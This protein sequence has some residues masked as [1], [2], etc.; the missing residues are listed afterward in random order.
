LV[1]GITDTATDDYYIV[2]GESITVN[3]EQ[4]LAEVDDEPVENP[5]EGTEPS[6]PTDSTEPS[7]PTNGTEPD[8]TEPTESPRGEIQVVV[9]GKDTLYSL[10]K[11]YGV[12]IEDLMAYNG[13]SDRNIIVTGSTLKIP[14]E[15][16]SPNEGTEGT[17]PSDPTEGP[18]GEIRIVVSS[19]DTLYSIAKTYGV[20]IEDLMAY[21]GISDRNIIV[22]GSTLKIPPEGWHLEES[23]EPTE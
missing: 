9:S 2:D 22:T 20:S 3:I 17:E 21:N 13:I 19:K 7:E 11:T 16:W 23:T 4:A 14:P 1:N 5:T 10:G 8:A 15:G 18:R 12:S 6:E